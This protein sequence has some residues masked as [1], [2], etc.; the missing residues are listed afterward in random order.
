MTHADCSING[1]EKVILHAQ[2]NHLARWCKDCTN[3]IL[4][5]IKGG[6]TGGG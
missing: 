2:E 5:E 3:K 6:G 1:L 4:N